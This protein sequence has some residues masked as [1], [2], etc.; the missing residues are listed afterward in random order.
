M[1]R[2]CQDKQE[3]LDS[4]SSDA[5]LGLTS[6]EAEKRLEENGKNKLAESKK[7]SVIR[8]F[9][10]QLADPMIIILIVAAAISGALTVYESVQAGKS[11]FP[12]DVI[13]ILAVVL[14]NAILGV[15]QESIGVQSDVMI[16]RCRTK[17][18]MPYKPAS[19]PIRAEGILVEVDPSTNRASKI[20]RVSF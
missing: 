5:K 3:V 20:E 6:A 13:I 10:E 19:G 9:F 16:H 4:L 12:T 11:E 14:I 18:P 15:F 1:K 7:K 8:R 2:Y 17:L